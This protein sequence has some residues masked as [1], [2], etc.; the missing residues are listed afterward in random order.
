MMEAMDVTSPESLAA[1]RATY[2][3]VADAYA[4]TYLH[5]LDRKPLDRALLSCFA[6]RVAADAPGR[7]V[8]DLG[9]G[10]GHVA[11][12][13]HGLGLRAFGLDLSPA[14]VALARQTFPHLG[15]VEGTITAAGVAD[16]SLGGIVSFYSIIH[17][18]VEELP[19]VFAEFHRVL[20]SG[21]WL[22]MAFHLGDERLHAEEWLGQRVDLDG[23]LLPLTRVVD[24]LTGA[25]FAVSAQL[26]REPE[27]AVEAPFRRGYLLARTGRGRG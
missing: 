24:L 1:T 19:V 8:G 5:E 6:E 2:D 4:A 22:L 26:V 10:P 14:M 11:A 20:V 23:Y 9:C 12:H 3:A 17:L 13:L 27:P 25:G 21:G 16:R 7:A 15:F 18:P